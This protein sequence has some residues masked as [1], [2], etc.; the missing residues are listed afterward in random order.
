MRYYLLRGVPQFGD[1]DFSAERFSTL[2][3]SDL[4]NGLGNL[5]SRLFS[6]AKRG[7]L[8]SVPGWEVAAAAGCSPDIASP[9]EEVLGDIWSEIDVLNRELEQEK[10][11]VEIR[12]GPTPGLQAKLT[13]W[14]IQLAGI[15]GRIDPYLPV[16]AASIRSHFALRPLQAIAPLF[17]RRA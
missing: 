16:T 3:E 15:T 9:H 11:W 8:E 2:Y 6:L 17:P 5:V 12:N 7:G 14:L 10:P 4:V 1:A 13:H